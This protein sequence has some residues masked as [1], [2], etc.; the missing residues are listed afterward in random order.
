MSKLIIIIT[1]LFAAIQI[2]LAA[3]VSGKIIDETGQPVPFATVQIESLSIGATADAQGFFTL[4][5]IQPGNF[6]IQASMLGYETIRKEISVSESGLESLSLRLASSPLELGEVKVETERTTSGVSDNRAVRTEIIQGED[7]VEKSTTGNLMSALAGETGLKTRPCAMC[8][9]TGVGMQGMEASYTEVKVDGLSIYSGVGT[10]YGLDGISAS[11]ISSVELVKGSGSSLN[12]SAAIA[13]SM[14]LNTRA[15]A[16]TNS[17]EARMSSD[18]YGQSSLYLAG[19][20]LSQKYPMRLS[21]NLGTEPTR[22]DEDSDGITDRPE[23]KRSNV[24]Y[25]V[26]LPLNKSKLTLGARAYWENRFAGDLDWTTS[27]R[28][29]SVL[30]GREILTRRQELS[31]TWKAPKGEITQWSARGALVNHDQNS[32]YGVQQFNAEQKLGIAALTLNRF[33][34]AM[35]STTFEAGVHAEDYNDNLELNS[36]TDL[37]QTVPAFVAEH[38][39]HPRANLAILLGTRTEYYK[40]DGVVP[41][42][43]LALAYDAGANTTLRFTAGTGYR[44]VNIFSLDAAAMAGFENMTLDEQ[45]KPERSVAFSAALSQRWTTRSYTAR[46]DA[47]L[48]L[49]DFSSKAIIKLGDGNSVLYTNASAAFARGF[50]LQAQ[51]L[52]QNGWKTKAGFSRSQNRYYLNGMWHDSHLQY[53]YTADGMLGRDWKR[54]GISADVNANVYGSQYL[55]MGRGRDKS[56]TYVLWN[57]SVRKAWNNFSASFGVNNIFDWL[58]SDEPYYFD[59]VTGRISPDTA[60]FYGP[61]LGRTF[62][63]SLGYNFKS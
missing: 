55:P 47:N 32:W 38:N 10:L 33:W 49:T 7:L 37:Q 34:N 20:G 17:Y 54:S 48:F 62:T 52:H 42:P 59:P 12:G 61:I 13:G 58:Q 53:T 21:M 31:A 46:V 50:E 18:Q 8:G 35:H 22:I 1:A 19:S 60:L 51:W 57:T 2:S 40:D 5:N 24:Q 4:E 9:A 36:Q 15:P 44:P 56:P 29:S 16:Q 39:W 3:S 23:Y 14:N 26:D 6:T 27:D 25:L 30:Y 11:D 28:G 43:R 45:L 63:L 41:T